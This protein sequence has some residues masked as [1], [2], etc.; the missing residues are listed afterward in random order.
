ME[1]RKRKIW[2]IEE[3]DYMITHYANESSNK[4]ATELKRPLC[5]IYGRANTL[6]LSKS[7]E[8]IEKNCRWQPGSDVGKS[9]QFHK[10]NTPA[11]KGK[12]MSADAYE[13]CKHT[14]FKK[15]QKPGNLLFDGAISTRVDTRT[16]IAYKYIR[17]AENNWDLLHRVNYKKKYGDIPTTTYLRCIDGNQ[18]NCD[19]DNWEPITMVKNMELNTIHQYPKE[20]Q[21]VIKLNNNLK[22]QIDGRH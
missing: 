7:P 3:D 8:Y 20:L 14:M 22:K 13:K 21:E 9:T 4:I 19:P 1:K 6:G 12:K 11:N 18:L 15:G 2:T 5:S 16:G 17:L 10:G